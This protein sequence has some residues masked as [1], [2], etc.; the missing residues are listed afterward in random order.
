[1]SA[2]P[3]PPDSP[4]P[5]S[6]AHQSGRRT[7]IP[8]DLSDIAYA[9]GLRTW[10]TGGKQALAELVWRLEQIKYFDVFF[11]HELENYDW[12]SHDRDPETTVNNVA[13]YRNWIFDRNQIDHPQN[14]LNRWFNSCLVS[15]RHYIAIEMITLV[16][17]HGEN[18]LWFPRSQAHRDIFAYVLFLYT[19]LRSGRAPTIVL[20]LY[21]NAL[22]YL[23]KCVGNTEEW[24][25]ET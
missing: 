18:Y 10:M 3:A 11:L 17:V 12:T 25:R 23:C 20:E 19:Y 16:R 1:M 5:L 4:E 7:Q 13:V 14:E 6:P 9:L 22:R 15:W 21:A 2:N 24:S 8:E